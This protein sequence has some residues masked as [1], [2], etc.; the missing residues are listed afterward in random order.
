MNEK[1]KNLYPLKWFDYRDVTPEG[2]DMLFLQA[3]CK[4][5]NDFQAFYLIDVRFD[6][7]GKEYLK[8]LRWESLQDLL[9]DGKFMERVS[10]L[11]RSAD[12][13][14]IP[15]KLFWSFAF[16][17]LA[18]VDNLDCEITSLASS[19]SSRASIFDSY[20]ERFSER[21]T[22]SEHP[23]MFPANFSGLKSQIEY[24]TYVEEEAK[25]RYPNTWRGKLQMLWAQGQFFYVNQPTE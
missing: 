25:K 4:A 1:E 24:F 3:W 2:A 11:R 16:E 6:S 13:N 17:L 12:K 20:R 19:I 23:R 15:Y 5:H 22:I 14:G 7:D 9:D 21:V 18:D 8:P 10:R